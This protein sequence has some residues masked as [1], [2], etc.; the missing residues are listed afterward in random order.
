MCLLLLIMLQLEGLRISQPKPDT[1]KDVTANGETSKDGGSWGNFS[2]SFYS[3]ISE[4][5]IWLDECV[6]LLSDFESFN[7]FLYTKYLVPHVMITNLRGSFLLLTVLCSFWRTI[8]L[9]TYCVYIRPS[10][11]DC[12]FSP[13]FLRNR[14]KLYLSK[15]SDL[16]KSCILS[17]TRKGMCLI[18]YEIVFFFFFVLVFSFLFCSSWRHTWV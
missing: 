1:C 11:K 5:P 8:S 10:L 15:V 9:I 12:D 14:T 18:E 3:K 2:R 17:L 4:L 16:M 7:S 13:L 6:I